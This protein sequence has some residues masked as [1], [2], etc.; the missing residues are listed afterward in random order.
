MQRFR[1]LLGELGFAESD[2]ALP[3]ST[4]RFPDGA[5]YRVELP[6]VEGPEVFDAVLAEA[7]ARGVPVHRVSQG[8]GGMLL[9]GDE[10]ARM[11]EIGVG[12]RTE[13]SLFARPLAGWSTGAA[14]LTSVRAP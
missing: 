2:H 12:A 5:Q 11:T 14:A 7:A 13:V 6:S 8:S 3:D 10:L 1:E 9:T 4:K